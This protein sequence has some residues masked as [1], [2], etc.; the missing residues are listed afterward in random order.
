[1]PN[2]ASLAHLAQG[3]DEEAVTQALAPGKTSQF[4]RH[5][6]GALR[7][8]GCPLGYDLAL[9]HRGYMADAW[10][11]QAT[12]QLGRLQRHG[13]HSSWVL[14]AWV[15]PGASWPRVGQNAS[16]STSCSL[17][18]AEG[19]LRRPCRM[20]SG[21]T[22][23]A[24][25]AKATP[26]PGASSRRRRRA[27]VA[28]ILRLSLWLQG[29]PRDS[30]TGHANPGDV[31]DFGYDVGDWTEAVASAK[32]AD[33]FLDLVGDGSSGEFRS[34]LR[35]RQYGFGA[36][37][38]QGSLQDLGALRVAAGIVASLPGSPQTVLRVELMAFLF[39]PRHA[40]GTLG[41][42]AEN[43]PQVAFAPSCRAEGR[44][45]R[46]AVGYHSALP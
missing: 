38:M 32:G 9:G 25:G 19:S 20:G 7:W 34:D 6:Q 4:G 36:A 13:E 24:W 29:V 3:A 2:E 14:H 27:M 41:Y 33:G 17:V 42:H 21:S 12:M 23:A 37:A 15:M 16:V 18:R 44:E 31:H 35:L 46:L 8:L 1:M 22:R 40:S 43:M 39:A 5:L 30:W 10:Q 11:Y 26:A 45:C 28:L